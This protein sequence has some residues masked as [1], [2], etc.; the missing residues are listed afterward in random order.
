MGQRFCLQINS[1]R[2]YQADKI[3]PEK[4]LNADEQNPKMIRTRSY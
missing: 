3:R 1:Q 4:I 2:L